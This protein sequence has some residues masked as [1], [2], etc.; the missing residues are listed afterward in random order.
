MITMR[1]GERRGR[2]EGERR[3]SRYQIVFLCCFLPFIAYCSR[4]AVDVLVEFDAR[5]AVLTC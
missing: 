4:T 3:L 2:S 1:D 5:D